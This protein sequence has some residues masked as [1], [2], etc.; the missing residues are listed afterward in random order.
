MYLV[1]SNPKG[2]PGANNII[3]E[4]VLKIL[5]KYTV[6]IPFIEVHKIATTVPTVALCVPVVPASPNRWHRELNEDCLNAQNIRKKGRQKQD[7]VRSETKLVERRNLL[8]LPESQGR[9]MTPARKILLAGVS[10]ALI[11]IYRFDH[12]TIRDSPGSPLHP[13]KE[14]TA[15]RPDCESRPPTAPRTCQGEGLTS[16]QCQKTNVVLVTRYRQSQPQTGLQVVGR[17]PSGSRKGRDRIPLDP[18]RYLTAAR[19]NCK[20]RSAPYRTPHGSRRETDRV[21]VGSLTET[22]RQGD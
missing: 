13:V 20:S 12:T 8:P 10:L 6:R 16:H 4:V 2:L 7:D 15:A 22:G 9:F 19:P 17:S 3:L 18:A 11:Y 5:V 14:T 1:Q 21:P